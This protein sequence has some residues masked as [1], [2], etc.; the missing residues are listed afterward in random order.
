[1]S[2]TVTGVV[3]GYPGQEV[4][5]GLDLAVADGETVAIRGASGTGKSTLLHCVGLLDH[6]DA[7]S[8]AIDGER[9]DEKCFNQFARC[10]CE[11]AEDQYAILIF[12]G[13][14]KFLGNKIHAVMQAVNQTKIGCAHQFEHLRRLLMFVN[15]DDGFPRT[16]AESGVNALDGSVRRNL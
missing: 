13:G 7:G 6:P 5:R 12:P 14:D 10:A 9:V 1:M 2:L 3:K 16:L 4:L 8:I 15:Q 11:R